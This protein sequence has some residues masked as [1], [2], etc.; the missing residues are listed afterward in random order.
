[1][2]I[3]KLKFAMS[4]G[5]NRS[6]IISSLKRANRLIKQKFQSKSTTN[7]FIYVLQV[8]TQVNLS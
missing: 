6:T 7:Y 3:T 4:I 2:K 1:M 5:K 8:K